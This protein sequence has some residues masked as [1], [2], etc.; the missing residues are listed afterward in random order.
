MER[1]K[2]A[3]SK[4]TSFAAR[5]RGHILS[6]FLLLLT[7]TAVY[8]RDF[9]ILA[10][11]ALHNEAASHIILVPFLVGF[12]IY[13]SRDS[14]KA[15]ISFK[16]LPRKSLANYLDE[17]TGAA[18]CLVAFLLYW[19]GSYTFYPLEFH[20]LSLPIFSAGIVL[21]LFGWKALHALIFPILFLAFLVPPP[22]E[23]IYAIG[24]EM[25]NFNTQASY[26]ILS[27]LGL[28]VTLETTYGPPT[29]AI[30]TSGNPVYFA[31]DVACSGI[32]SIT[33]FLMFATFLVYIIIAPSFKKAGIFVLGFIVFQLLNIV[34]I[35]TIIS[36]GYFFG[37]EIAMF[38]FHT[39]TGWLLILAGMLLILF[40]ADRFWKIKF[41]P[42]TTQQPCPTCPTSSQNF[43]TFCQNCGR[44]LGAIQSKIS[45]KF[46]AKLTILLVSSYLV[47]LSI[48]APTFAIAQGPLGI[49]SDP[50]WQISTEI[51]PEIPD[52]QLRFIYRDTNYEKI[53]G[54]DASL[55]YAYIPT[56]TTNKTIYVDLSIAT[57]ISN[58]HNWEVCL[59][60]WQLSLGRQPL[61]TVLD[62]RDT[63]LL[64]DHPIIARYL[65]FE[66]P[67]GYTQ[68]T[69]YWFEQATFNLG[70][71]TA[72]RYVRISLIIL[73][74]NST[75]YPQ[76]ENQLF[77]FGQSIA[78]HW[79]PLE[80]QSLISIGV[81]MQQGLLGLSI[82]FITVTKTAEYTRKWRKKSSTL[83]IFN[84]FASPTEKLVLET[85][86]ELSKE[87][88]NAQTKLI[89][90]TLASKTE[91][92]ITLTDLDSTLKELERHGLVER[93]IVKVEDKPIIVW[94]A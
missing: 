90:T 16:K 9:T 73:T 67:N 27:N 40:I 31:I 44:F 18:L 41:S 22:A 72:Q 55:L 12:L 13:R 86:Q 70:F 64:D 42:S 54:Q 38:I 69:L 71:T 65:V 20:L 36:M 60:T 14:V 7:V 82:G 45:R 47:T 62:S 75:N 46:W 50:N 85:V 76:L 10:N 25:A 29:I 66:N 23:I 5:Y 26:T 11:E 53:A 17:A 21:I 3:F 83:R 8:W 93:K 74:L 49:T 48:Q 84:N 58:L 59:I 35:T 88:K 51:F 92:S 78:L 79:Q 6:T 19:Y 43:E 37:E 57:T 24:G 1:L 81:P 94:T 30:L 80:A 34:R 89:A 4:S 28:P 33:A 15:S 52:Y 77:E 32:Y 68:T 91:K 87:G 61:V 63:Q 39:M 2:T 56:N